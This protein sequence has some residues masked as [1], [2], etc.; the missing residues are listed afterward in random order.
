MSSFVDHAFGQ[1]VLL[2]VLH[3]ILLGHV[4]LEQLVR[5]V[6]RRVV[7]SMAAPP[8]RDGFDEGGAAAVTSAVDRFERRLEDLDDVSAVDPDAGMPYADRAL[9][10]RGD[11]ELER[12]RCGVGVL[13]V[14]HDP[15]DG[16]PDAP[17]TS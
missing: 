4:S 12:V 13:V 1:Q 16:Q 6:L 14:V 8:E 3:R 9:G 11:A 17:P 10:D 15:D 5:H 2:E 7:A